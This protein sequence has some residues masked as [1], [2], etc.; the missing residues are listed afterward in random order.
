MKKYFLF[1]ALVP[2][3][4][5]AQKSK[6]K[7]KAKTV[8]VKNVDNKEAVK[9]ANSYV[10]NGTLKGYPDGTMVSLLNGNTGQP[11]ATSMIQKDKFTLT[12]KVD[13]P[14]FKLIS[15]NSK[16][17]Y[18]AVF[19][20]NSNVQIT[21]DA[22]TFQESAVTG[23]QS[24]NEF[25]ELNNSMK[26]FEQVFSQEGSSDA[27]LKAQASKLLMD[28]IKKYP[29]SY[30]SPLAVYRNYQAT[31]SL[32]ILDQLF[33]GL[34]ESVKKGAVGNYIAQQLVDFRRNPIGK[35]LADF[36]QADSTGKMVSLSSLKGKYVLIDFWASW[37]GPCRQ[38]NPNVVATY[39]K[40]K[41]K[42][43]TVLGV[44][45]DKAKQPWLDAIKMD[46]LTWTHVSDLQ[47][48]S[49][50]VGQ[51]FQIGSIP[52]NFLIDPNGILIAKNLRGAALE[53]KLASLLGN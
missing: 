31:G 4:G 38:E 1:I 13:L 18:I 8:A 22:A 27:A 52:Q 21:G 36:A 43:Y 17:P 14:D 46:G 19:L 3:I 10:I 32:E 11:E 9:A 51:Q 26:P 2:M 44:S 20:D 37:C 30:V 47:G 49:N 6:T 15:I 48:W 7:T 12:G 42:N 40:Y 35:P 16:A 50:A 24:H 53:S 25:L 5:F 45:F 33:T 28:F 41:N 23:S 34:D 39:N 29:K